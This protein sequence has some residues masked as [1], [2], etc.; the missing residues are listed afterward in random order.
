MTD[1]FENVLYSVA[2]G[3]ARITKNNPDQ[4]IGGTLRPN[5]LNQGMVR[6]LVAALEMAGNDQA[7]R[8]IIIDAA[9]QGIHCGAGSIGNILREGTPSMMLQAIRRGQALTQLIEAIP[10]PVIYKIGAYATGGG[11][12]MSY[13]C[14]FVY[15]DETATLEQGE[16][17]IGIIPG[18]G[19]TQRLPRLAGLRK[20]TEIIMLGEKIGAREAEALGIIT[21]AVPG[22]QLE[23]AV[24]TLALKLAAKA[25]IGLELAKRAIRAGLETNLG[26]GLAFEAVLEALTM[27]SDQPAEAVRAR[28]EQRDPDFKPERRLTPGEHEWR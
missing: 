6:D 9:G 17:A 22:D 12:E 10:K 25:P 3:I 11:C 1:R 14:D 27:T 18:W 2:S 4:V 21:R 15:A 19:G 13:A 28:T 26:T 20:A 24:W 8:V 5:A 16:I 7:V 23:G